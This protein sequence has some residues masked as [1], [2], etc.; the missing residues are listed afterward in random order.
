MLDL[1]PLNEVAKALKWEG[2]RVCVAILNG[3]LP[4]GAA[5]A[6]QKEGEQYAARIPR[7]RWE[8]WKSGNL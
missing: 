6:P 5:Y 4:I 3:T 1:V 7:E 2:R 8:K